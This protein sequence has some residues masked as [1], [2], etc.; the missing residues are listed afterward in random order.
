M[1]GDHERLHILA[2]AFVLGGL[3]E[4]EHRAFAAHLRRCRDCQREV[5]ELGGLPLLLDLAEE[6]D[7]PPAGL[8]SAQLGAGR[9]GEL[10]G[11]TGEA[12][13]DLVARLRTRRRRARLR[14]GAA[15]ALIGVALAGGGTVVGVTAGRSGG[16]ATTVPSQPL[17][18]S[19][20]PGQVV[21][22]SVAFVPKAWGTEVHLDGSS[23]PTAGEFAL[24]VRDSTGRVDRI[25]TW[26][27]TDAGRAVL[28]AACAQQLAELRAVEI[29][30][31]AGQVLAA[32]AI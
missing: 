6:P 1:T 27:G 11:R 25:A 18:M 10:G 7:D 20:A 15:A 14:W 13:T 2:G 16:T 29:R 32:A 9:A 22:V 3:S 19:A 24:W 5:G 30:T 12:A 28:V 21:A 17:A 4:G 8:G 23:L 31:R 26:R